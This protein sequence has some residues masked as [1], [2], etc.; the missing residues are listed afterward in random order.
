MNANDHVGAILPAQDLEADS[1]ELK[2]PEEGAEPRESAARVY[3]ARFC[4][5]SGSPG[6]A[7]D[8]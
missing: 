7:S 4:F 3:A 5:R 6:Y 1:P 2:E 8:I